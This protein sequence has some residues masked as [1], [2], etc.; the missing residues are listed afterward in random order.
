MNVRSNRGFPALPTHTPSPL[1]RENLRGRLQAKNAILTDLHLP[2]P[3]QLSLLPQGPASQPRG[4]ARCP[5][6]ARGS[7]SPRTAA[8]A[9][10]PVF[11]S[12]PSLLLLLADS[13]RRILHVNNI[14]ALFTVAAGPRGTHASTIGE[15][16]GGEK[17]SAQHLYTH[18]A[19]PLHAAPPLGGPERGAEGPPA[20]SSI[21]RSA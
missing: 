10:T 19:P 21:L 7:P 9:G 13:S 4:S 2:A 14:Q 18:P 6:T 16:G 12:P 8:A 20:P 3:S 15:G 5:D 11:L 17:A 1:A